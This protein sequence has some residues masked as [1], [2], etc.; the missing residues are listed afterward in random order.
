MQGDFSKPMTLSQKV[1]QKK[2]VIMKAKRI[3]LF[4]SVGCCLAIFC[5]LQGVM[6]E[7]PPASKVYTLEES[8]AE[9]LENNWSLKAVGEKLNQ[10]M[11]QKNR[12]RSDFLPTFKTQYSYTRLDNVSK[13]ESSY[14]GN[15]AVS[16]KDNY[17]WRNSVT[18][19]LFAGFGLVSA[20]RY[21]KLG[22]DQAQVEVELNKVDLAL[23]VKEAYFNVL[24]MDKVV[25]VAR[26]EVESLSSN[27]EMTDHFYK[28]GMIP[29][30]DLLKAELELANAQQKLVEA[31][32]QLKLVRFNFNIILARPV[33]EPVEVKDIL[34]YEPEVVEFK[35][36]ADRAM[37]IRPEIKA[38]DIGIQR[39][40]QQETLARS[41]YYP[42]VSLNYDYI[43]E[44]NE[45]SV[46]GSP[47]HD[48]DRWQALMAF[49]W[50]F[51]DWGK[52]YYD[53]QEKKSVT[54]ELMKNRK[55]VEEK[56]MIDVKEATLNL[57]TAEKNIP[58][59]EKAVL[60]GE[61]N[62]RVNEEGYRAKVNTITDVLD[63][64]SLLTQARVNYYKA[65][66]GH[67]LAKAKLL[68]AV[69]TY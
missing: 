16:S 43:K 21:A 25:E 32:N 49:S 56:I 39:A 65:L 9:A 5:F 33:D 38:I 8:I 20:F 27:V 37:H 44:G 11:D 45:A 51:W 41:N 30:N 12:T 52:T 4:L 54:D 28:K 34:K 66:Y 59:T 57:D 19:P 53:V 2:E 14:G 46:S 18:Q 68:R 36:T 3:T 50:N 35:E 7:E 17:Q 63:A 55:A 42:F 62:L 69:G 26:K 58:T 23:Q 67:H 15:V 13:Y 61:E 48:A 60:Q 10:A 6:A 22:I 29:I 40:L 1:K 31:Q 64:Q 24:V 47:Y